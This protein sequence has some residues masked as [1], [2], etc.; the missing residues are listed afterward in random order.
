MDLLG[1][2]MGVMALRCLLVDDSRYFLD[3]AS[4]L[5][6]SQGLAVAGTSLPEPCRSCGRA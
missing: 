2:S 5:L 3:A 6:V 4:R 1:H